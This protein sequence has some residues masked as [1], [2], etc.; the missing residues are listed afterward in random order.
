MRATLGAVALV[1]LALSAAC[2]GS[3]QPMEPST[4]PG[5]AV[6]SVVIASAMWAA[7]GGCNLQGCPYGSHCNGKTGFCDVTKCA[8]GCP[9]DTVC[10]EG[11]GLCQAPPPAE[12]PSDFLPDDI[13][14]LNTVPGQ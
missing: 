10:N 6:G 2:G 3:V 9:S 7:A 12:G 11:L 1:W 13:N 4:S 5:L 8:Q 14:K